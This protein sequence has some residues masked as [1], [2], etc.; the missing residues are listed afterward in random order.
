MTLLRDFFVT[1]IFLFGVWSLLRLAYVKTTPLRHKVKNREPIKAA[2]TLNENDRF[3][4]DQEHQIWPDATF[5]HFNC[6]VCG[7]GPLLQGTVPSTYYHPFFRKEMRTHDDGYGTWQVEELVESNAAN[8]EMVSST[9]IEQGGYTG[10]HTV[11][12]DL[13]FPVTVVQSTTV[14]HHHLY[15]DHLMTW[16]Q[17]RPLLKALNQAGL[18]EDG[19]YRAAIRQSATMLRPPWV[20]KTLPPARPPRPSRPSAPPN[21]RRWDRRA[22]PFRKG[23][24]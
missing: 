1:A 5:E 10:K 18:I 12:L 13:D 24:R 9:V 14:G 2:I 3:I 17:Y 23:S 16:K 4:Q 19:Y 22:H 8:A 11:M 6:A 7:P 15:I 20:K 21:A